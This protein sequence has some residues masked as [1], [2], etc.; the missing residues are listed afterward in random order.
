MKT[1]KTMAAVDVYAI[2]PVHSSI[3]F[4]VRHMMINHSIGH[5]NQ[6][7]GEVSFDPENMSDFHIS[8]TIQ[9]D[10]IDTR[11][12]DRDDHLKGADFFDVENYST[13]TFNSNSVTEQNGRYMVSGDLTMKGITKKLSFPVNIEG[14]VV[15]AQGQSVIGITGQ[16]TIN[17]Q[18]FGI[19]F[20]KTVENNVPMVGN[21]VQIDINIEAKK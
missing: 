19:S 3:T 12:K 18:S 6:F 8:V 13:I 5:F 20:N 7:E 21:D 16:I 2:D 17:R 11:H 14:P 4:K 10:S 9:V 15:N 1:N